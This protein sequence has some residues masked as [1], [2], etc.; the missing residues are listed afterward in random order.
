MAAQS[1]SV[2]AIGA[3]L[4]LP[5]LSLL[6][7]A[8]AHNAYAYTTYTH[9][10]KASSSFT[11]RMLHTGWFDE[12]LS[13]Y[14]SL[15]HE[16]TYAWHLLI[17]CL[18]TVLGPGYEIWTSNSNNHPLVTRNFI[19]YTASSV[20]VRS[21]RYVCV[22]SLVPRFGLIL[23]DKM[24]NFLLKIDMPTHRQSDLWG[25]MSLPHNLAHEIKYSGLETCVGFFALK[26]ELYFS[27]VFSI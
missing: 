21:K 12:K 19:C 26:M 1:Q 6:R 25:F 22:T 15:A 2:G 24:D 9:L 8:R 11:N 10:Q 18:W 5:C 23:P 7:S 14:C 20:Q 17:S 13:M 4:P 3:S 16:G 27:V